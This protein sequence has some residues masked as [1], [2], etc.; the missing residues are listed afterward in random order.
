MGP[1]GPVVIDFGIARALDSPG[2]T[3]T[4]VAMGT[5]SYLA[6]EQL[7]PGEVTP[8]ADVFAW[9]VTMVFAATGTPAFGQ[10]SIPVVINRILNTEPELGALEGELRELVA[11]CLSKDP[12]LRP[13]A[14]QLVNRL[15]GTAPTTPVRRPAPSPVPRRIPATCPRRPCGR[16]GNAR[17]DRRRAGRETSRQD[18][19]G[20]DT[21]GQDTAAPA[22]TG[23][24]GGR[25]AALWGSCSPGWRSWPRSAWPPPGP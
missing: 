9:G 2:M 19:A 18:R 4:G 21:A 15:M 23:P 5:P 20:R 25:H 10:D 14:E 8:A 12:A 22:R 7:G 11:A 6:P 16:A 3:A 17:T 1:E 13:T 24:G